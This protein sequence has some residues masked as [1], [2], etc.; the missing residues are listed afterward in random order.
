MTVEHSLT[1]DTKVF[2]MKVVD[3]PEDGVLCLEDTQPE[4]STLVLVEYNGYHNLE[5]PAELCRM[6]PEEDEITY[7]QPITKR[8]C[9]DYDANC[10]FQLVTRCNHEYVLTRERD[11]YYYGH[12]IENEDKC[13]WIMKSIV[14]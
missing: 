14:I 8:A 13:G 4:D 7:E 9:M 12:E 2:G 5:I 3:I 11:G 10:P 6:I 1:I